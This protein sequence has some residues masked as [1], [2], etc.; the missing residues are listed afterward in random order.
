LNIKTD[1]LRRIRP[2]LDK[3][4]VPLASQFHTKA[5]PIRIVYC[6]NTESE[7]FDVQRVTGVN[8]IKLLHQHTYRRHY[9][10]GLKKHHEYYSQCARMAKQIEV[11]DLYRP[12]SGFQL[13]QLID[14]VEYDLSNQHGL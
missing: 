2:Q 8:K 4:A 5:L 6:L 9:L 10:H 12:A 14:Y 11:V 7:R 3:F 1:A 13:D